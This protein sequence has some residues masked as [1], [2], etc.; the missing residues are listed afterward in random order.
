VI[1]VLAPAI[2]FGAQRA[3]QPVSTVRTQSIEPSLQLLERCFS[4]CKHYPSSEYV[5]K[6]SAIA[7]VT[8]TL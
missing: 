3:L 2:D 1:T 5:N 6:I 8:L 4:L 7:R